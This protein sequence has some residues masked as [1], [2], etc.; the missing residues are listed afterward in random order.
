M[1][2]VSVI[3]GYHL[4]LFVFFLCYELMGVWEQVFVQIGLVVNK[5][6]V[7]DLLEL[8]EVNT[9]LEICDFFSLCDLTQLVIEQDG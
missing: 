8:F 7:L 1:D 6:C 9:F 4:L 5:V 2:L 3:T